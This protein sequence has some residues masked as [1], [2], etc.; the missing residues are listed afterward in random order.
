MSVFWWGLGGSQV[1]MWA[2][3]AFGSR[4]APDANYDFTFPV[5]GVAA[6][7]GIAV[8]VVIAYCIRGAT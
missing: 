2:A 3:F 4:Y 1:G 7:L 6:F 5:M 8:G